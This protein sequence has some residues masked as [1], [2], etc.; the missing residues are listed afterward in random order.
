MTIFS[1]PRC[2]CPGNLDALHAALR[3][4]ELVN[5][6]ELH[7]GQGATIAADRARAD[8]LHA[9]A[10]QTRADTAAAPPQPAPSIA[11]VITLEFAKQPPAP[12]GSDLPLN[13][14]LDAYSAL[15]GMH[16]HH[17]PPG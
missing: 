5:R 10:D 8:A 1:D 6:C 3:D 2:T 9:L 16:V 15:S 14:P 13:A 4:T 17:A 7:T 11:E 12:A